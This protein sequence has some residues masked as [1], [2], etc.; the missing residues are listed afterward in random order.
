MKRGILGKLQVGM[1]LF[2]IAMGV[3][4]PVFASFFVEFRPGMKVPFAVACVAAGIAVGS[5]SYVLVRLILLAPLMKISWASRE[6]SSGNID[7]RLDIESPDAVGDIVGG[8]NTMLST[9][10]EL[11][12]RLAEGVQNLAQVTRTLSDIAESHKRT[13]TEE[14][15]HVSA[16]SSATHQSSVSLGDIGKTLTETADFSTRVSA[17]AQEMLEALGNSLLSIDETE[18]SIGK[19]IT[20]LEDF[21]KHTQGVSEILSIVDDIADQTNLL[22]LNAAIEAARAGEQGRGFAVVADE[23]RKLAEKTSSSTKKI[24]GLMQ[25]LLSGMGET[26]AGVQSHAER[27]A[28]THKTVQQSSQ[29]LDEMIGRVEQIA[30]RIQ[31]ISSSTVEHNAALESIDGSLSGIDVAFKGL[32]TDTRKLTETSEQVN[33]FSSTLKGLLEK[34]SLSR[35]PGARETGASR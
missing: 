32:L 31:A 13:I 30:S 24:G 11:L 26:I 33:S 4:F 34:L 12:S 3:V 8:F 35:T 10:R 17:Q 29:S 27:V 1:L 16:I 28:E 5:F 20:H 23:V 14:G 15:G 6:V 2:G 19:T 21:R 25:S 22:A 9:I 18:E 7:V